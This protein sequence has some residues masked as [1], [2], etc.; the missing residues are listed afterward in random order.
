MI[1]NAKRISDQ[2]SKINTSQNPYFKR[3]ITVLFLIISLLPYTFNIPGEIMDTNVYGII[4]FIFAVGAVSLAWK[5]RPAFYFKRNYMYELMRTLNFNLFEW[6]LVFI[7]EIILAQIIL[8]GLFFMINIFIPKSIEIDYLLF[9]MQIL[10]TNCF[11][12][13]FG[14][15]INFNANNPLSVR[16]SPKVTKWLS[17]ST[18]CLYGIIP[19]LNG[20]LNISNKNAVNVLRT[21]VIQ[22]VV[23]LLMYGLTCKFAGEGNGRYEQ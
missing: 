19:Q 9:F 13:A 6:K 15:V 7:F 12:L 23:L 2:V 20:N 17:F 21:L 11:I 10:K 3:E 8:Y 4:T 22:I 1:L 14:T 5:R 16:I 18:Y